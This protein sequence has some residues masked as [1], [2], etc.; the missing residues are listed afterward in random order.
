MKL[1]T[2]LAVAATLAVSSWAAVPPALG[3]APLA[4]AAAFQGAA[5]PTPAGTEAKKSWKHGRPEYDAFTAAAKA[6]GTE[7]ARLAAEFIQKY[8]DSDYKITA[9]QVEMQAQSGVPSLQPD[10]VKTAEELLQTPGANASQLMSA[11]VI[12]AYLQPNLIKSTDPNADAESN[13]LLAI[14]GCGAQLLPTAAPAAQQPAFAAIL[15]KAKGFAQLTLKQYDAAITTLSKVAQD[16]PKDPLPYYW[17]GIAEVT[18][19]TPDFNAGIFDLAKASVLAPSTGAIS[20]YLNTVYTSFHGSTD[21]LQDVIATAKSNAAPPA[22]FKVLS[23]S[24]V[25][26]NQA[27]AEYEKKKEELANQLPPADS[28]PGIKARL[29]KPN[30]APAEWKNVKGVG[31]EL[32]GIVTKVTDKIVEIAAYAKD[33]SAPAD[34]RVNLFTPLKARRPKVGQQVTVKGVA[35]AYESAPFMLVMKDGI[36]EGYEPKAAKPGE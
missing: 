15:S 21:G 19:A 11:D 8:P 20:N 34:V 12:I 22:D 35:S 18:K 28:F 31:Y 10:A 36:V 6:T 33:A 14:A 30:L 32:P 4:S 16:N 17:M 29:E 27:M 23:K 26:Y 3:A 7:Q 1:S 25:Q 9:L 13:K 2:T 5:C 24:D